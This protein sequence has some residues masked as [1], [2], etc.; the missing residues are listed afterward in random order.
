MA[1]GAARGHAAISTSGLVSR[2]NQQLHADTAPEKYA[3]LFLGIYDDESG[4]LTYTNAGHLP[5][6][7]IRRGECTR[8]E[9]NGTVAGAFPF[10][11]YDE[12]HLD[13]QEGDLVVLFTDGV[14]ET[15]NAYGE[16]YGEERLADLLVR[17]AHLPEDEIVQCVVESVVEW[18]GAAEAQKEL[19]DDMTLLLARGCSA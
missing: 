3:T 17:N 12:S 15:E 16:M 8:L 7:L 9:V 13:L 11:R 5:P 1:A 10:S 18:S 2:I 6:M 4:M 14:T 19:Q